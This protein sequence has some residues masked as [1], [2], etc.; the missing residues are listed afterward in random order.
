MTKE[1]ERKFMLAIAE[2]GKRHEVLPPDMVRLFGVITH[3]LIMF[4]VNVKNRDGAEVTQELV[5]AFMDGMG[6]SVEIEQ[7]NEEQARGPLQ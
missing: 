2:L 4:G 7:E 3:G 5:G 1:N 6:A